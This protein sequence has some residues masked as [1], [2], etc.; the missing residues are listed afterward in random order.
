MVSLFLKKQV[1]IPL[2]L[3][4]DDAVQLIINNQVVVAQYGANALQALGTYTGTIVLERGIPVPLEIRM[5]EANQGEGLRLFWR[6]PSQSSSTTWFQFRNELAASLQGIGTTVSMDNKNFFVDTQNIVEAFLVGVNTPYVLHLSDNLSEVNGIQFN[7]FDRSTDFFELLIQTLHSSAIDGESNQVWNSQSSNTSQI[8]G[9]L[10]NGTYFEVYTLRDGTQTYGFTLVENNRIKNMIVDRLVVSGDSVVSLIASDV[11]A[12]SGV[13]VN[14]NRIIE[15]QPAVINHIEQEYPYFNPSPPR[16]NYL[17]TSGVFATIDYLE[18]DIHD[19]TI[20]VINEALRKRVSEVRDEILRDFRALT[21]YEGQNRKLHPGQKINVQSFYSSIFRNV[22]TDNNSSFL[23]QELTNTV[24]I[25][26]NRF[27]SIN[28]TF[29]LIDANT[30]SNISIRFDYC[31]SSP[32]GTPHLNVI[33]SSYTLPIRSLRN[34]NL[35]VINAALEEEYDY[36]DHPHYGP[37][38]GYLQTNLLY[39]ISG[40][41][42]IVGDSGVHIP[43]LPKSMGVFNDGPSSNSYNIIVPSGI[44]ENVEWFVYFG[45]PSQ[46]KIEAISDIDLSNVWGE[47][48]PLTMIHYYDNRGSSNKNNHLFIRRDFNIYAHTA[49]LNSGMPVLQQ[50]VPGRLLPN[51][52]LYNTTEI[53]LPLEYPG[54]AGLRINWEVAESS[55]PT[56]PVFSSSLQQDRISL[57]ASGVLVINRGYDDFRFLL[58]G[59]LSGCC[60]IGS[61]GHVE[62]RMFEF[63]SAKYS[64][65]E[66]A[67]R[68]GAELTSQLSSIPR[69]IDLTVSGSNTLIASL[70]NLFNANTFSTESGVSIYYD[71]GAPFC[72]PIVQQGNGILDSANN[73]LFI[74]GSNELRIGALNVVDRSS[75]FFSV[76]ATFNNGVNNVMVNVD[77]EI[78]IRSPHTIT[79]PNLMQLSGNIPNYICWDSNNNR[80]YMEP[81][82]TVT[83]GVDNFQMGEALVNKWNGDYPEFQG[84]LVYR[85][86]SSVNTEIGGNAGIELLKQSAPDVALVVSNESINRQVNLYPLKNSYFSN[87]INSDSVLSS[88]SPVNSGGPYLLSAFW[89]SMSFSWNETMLRQLGVDVDTDSNGDGLPDAIDT[90]EKIFDLGLTNRTY[91][92]RPILEVFPI[93]MDEPWSAYSSISAG[94]FE[95]F[96]AGVPR[97]GFETEEFLGGLEFIKAFSQ[98]GINLDETGAKKAA[99]AMGWRWDAYLNDEAYPFGLVGTWMNVQA[100]QEATGSVFRFSA[101]PTWEGNQMRPLGQTKGFVING[102]TKYPSASAEVLR[103]LYTPSTMSSMVANSAYLPALQEGAFSSPEII[104]RIKREF[105]NGMRLNQLVP[106]QTL[107]NNPSRLAMDLYYNIGISDYYKAIWDGTLTPA[108]AQEQIVSASQAWLTANN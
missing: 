8:E 67:A 11:N 3:S 73:V 46:T 19:I 30:D 38:N 83:I 34:W 101:M 2:L 5:Y 94:G 32:C 106:G 24:S 59:T 1:P 57:N 84:R 63:I 88:V 23:G 22:G 7:D 107:P 81:G 47:E 55:W 86:F 18:Q 71:L 10:A 75:V 26:G 29:S 92:G 80:F 40:L 79:N 13:F 17:V 91:K 48:V 4:G 42:F 60:N 64:D 70:N 25:S 54:I 50:I 21:Q 72:Q 69:T 97:H 6:R 87:L 27:I 85:L 78:T 58:K 95:I 105:T 102:Y 44:V 12:S 93:S 103:W 36:S 37:E 43:T 74:N 68:L 89:D 51:S 16:F 39:Q 61:Q 33:G 96:G 62:S 99:S 9:K 14:L 35:D 52:Y 98:A 45:T 108:Q 90:W 100:A 82:S 28:P 15:Q 104:D 66:I 53:Q 56:V 65:D 41:R 76:Y 77:K 31:L 20:S 49:S